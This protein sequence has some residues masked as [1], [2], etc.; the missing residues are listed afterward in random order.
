MR[1]HPIKIVIILNHATL[2]RIEDRKELLKRN[3]SSKTSFDFTNKDPQRTHELCS[4]I[5]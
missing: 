4:N 1:A 5:E 2:S 3:L